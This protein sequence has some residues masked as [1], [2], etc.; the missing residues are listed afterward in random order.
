MLHWDSGRGLPSR[1]ASI[2]YLP[3]TY[4]G[5]NLIY[6]NVHIYLRPLSGPAFC[7]LFVYELIKLYQYHQVVQYGAHDAKEQDI[8]QLEEAAGADGEYMAGIL[9]EQSVIMQLRK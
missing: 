7:Q 1:R 5:S 6:K 8:V 4:L 3:K 2:T 9:Q